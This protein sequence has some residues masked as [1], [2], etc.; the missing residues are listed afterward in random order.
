MLALDTRRA[1]PRLHRGGMKP[2]DTDVDGEPATIAE[3]PLETIVVD[4]TPAKTV[5]VPDDAPQT[6]R[7][8]RAL[9]LIPIAL[10][11]A[12]MC[13]LFAVLA[14]DD[15]SLSAEC[16]IEPRSGG[17]RVRCDA[18]S[19]R[20][21]AVRVRVV[22]ILDRDGDEVRAWEEVVELAPGQRLTRSYDFPGQ[23]ASA[24]ECEVTVLP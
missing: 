6:K 13:V 4:E 1:R 20:D 7:R 24:C 23:R 12:L 15:D 14:L 17:V 8:S 19:A 3:A 10:G 2:E 9:V 16:T 18:E 5:F 22:P 21:E 11:A